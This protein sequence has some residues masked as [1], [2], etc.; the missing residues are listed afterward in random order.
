MRALLVTLGMVYVLSFG[1]TAVAAERMNV[2]V[3]GDSFMTSNGSAR[4]SVPHVLSSLLKTRVKSKAVT[5]ARHLYRLPIT[6]ALGMNISKQYRPGK[7]DVVVMNGGGN[8]LWMGC[9]CGK[10]TRKMARLISPDGKRGAI[11]SVVARARADGARVIYVGYLRSPGRGSPIEGCKPLGDAL[12]AR[13]AKLA[14]R[15]P[16]MTFVTLADMVPFGDR[17]FHAADMI[18]PSPKGSAAAARR[19]AEAIKKAQKSSF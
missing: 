6:G 1:S 17:S 13:I 8:D 11:P 9:G 3:M 19:V 5:G 4:Q 14:A 10:C 12:E 2:L 7:W 15:D 16:G 18:H